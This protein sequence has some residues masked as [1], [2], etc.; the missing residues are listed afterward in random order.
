MNYRAHRLFAFFRGH[1]HLQRTRTNAIVKRSFHYFDFTVERN[2]ETPVLCF[3]LHLI[4]AEGEKIFVVPKTA[5]E[6]PK[7]KLYKS[8]TTGAMG[9]VQTQLPMIQA[10]TQ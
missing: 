9:D 1:N 6:G 8:Q 2:P 5:E 4:G 3:N 10:I 7:R